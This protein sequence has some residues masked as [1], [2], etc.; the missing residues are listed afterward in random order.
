M[1]LEIDRLV[2]TNSDASRCGLW[3]NLALVLLLAGS[4]KVAKQLHPSRD[5]LRK[6]VHLARPARTVVAFELLRRAVD[7]D[8]D[9]LLLERFVLVLSR[10]AQGLGEPGRPA[11]RRRDKLVLSVATQPLNGDVTEEREEMR[12]L[13]YPIFRH[14]IG[15]Q[16]LSRRVPQAERD[17]GDGRFF[18]V[19]KVGKEELSVRCVGRKLWCWKLRARSRNIRVRMR[20]AV[21]GE[22]VVR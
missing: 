10:R 14:A 19:G 1:I 16:V 12:R 15:R 18:S 3:R 13:P 9:E 4:L 6:V 8:A 17:E 11:L 5:E 20:R 2:E 21:G 7:E 22:E